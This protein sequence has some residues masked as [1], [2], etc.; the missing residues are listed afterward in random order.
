MSLSWRQAVVTA[1]LVTSTVSAHYNG[2]VAG[3][4][5]LEASKRSPGSHAGRPRGLNLDNILSQL[6]GG[7][8]AAAGTALRMGQSSLYLVKSKC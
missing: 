2:A 7:Q 4:Q 6:L 1:L 3:N 8:G 5:Q